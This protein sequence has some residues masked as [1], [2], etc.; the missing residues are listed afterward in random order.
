MSNVVI[1]DILPYTQAIAIASQ[2]VFGT[3]WTADAASDVVVYL[4]PEGEDAD[5]ATQILTDSDFSVAFI[6]AEQEVEITLVNPASEGDIITIT[7]MTP[8][9]RENLYSA[10]NFT[11]EML[12]NDFGIL[13]LVDQQAQLVNQLVAPRYNY[14][15]VIEDVVDTILP[16]L[17]PNQIW[18]KNSNDT[19]IEAYTVTGAAGSGNVNPGS[20]N[21]LAW[22]ET[23]SST[24]N[25]LA[26]ANSSL[27][28]TSS[29][30]VPSIS[31]NLPSGL[32][33]PDVYDT[34]GNIVVDFTGV[35]SATDYIDI[36]N[37]IANGAA[38]SAKSSNSNANLN[39]LSKGTG[40]V[41]MGSSDPS[42]TVPT[43]MVKGTNTILFSVPTLTGNRTV[44]FPDA[45]VNLSA[46]AAFNTINVRQFTSNDTYTPTAG[47]LYAIVEVQAGG[48]GGGGVVSTLANQNCIA[49]GG[50]GGA[51]SSG[52]F[53][54]ATIGASQ[55]ITIGAAGT[56]G[57]NT[58]GNGGNGG[59]SSFGTL[60]VCGGGNGGLGD[61]D[62]ANGFESPGGAG[63]TV[64]TPGNI[65]SIAGQR[66]S[67]GFG[68]L[69]D[70]IGANGGNSHLGLGGTARGAPTGSTPYANSGDIGT[71][72][73]AGG[74]GAI[75]LGGGGAVA[76]TAGTQGI[77]IITEFIYQ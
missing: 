34:N 9:D 24:V 39:L 77:I 47:L 10:T 71:G 42:N 26:T 53:D 7:R 69:D 70:G 75:S 6:G 73:G 11:P 27:L 8:A 3:N 67:T 13:T 59:T 49:S 4:T 37:G 44:T 16:I 28:V 29:S 62:A 43:T 54:A 50:G 25:G 20:A 35:A 60:I 15:A 48:G 41:K 17:G 64:S 30:G 52:N 1:G 45:D 51:Y 76:G 36:A 19:A 23:T 57:A 74:S 40:T 63:G 33:L 21:Q 18:I 72:Y 38:L 46:I 22:Y 58:G 65:L 66:G 68:I 5:D 56:A 31:N 14:S 61:A 12:N 2:T 32:R 55:A